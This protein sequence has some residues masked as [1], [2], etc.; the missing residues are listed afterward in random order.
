MAVL[1]AP[2]FGLAALAFLLAYWRTGKAWLE[3]TPFVA[4]LVG[5]M[6]AGGSLL[7]GYP[8]YLAVALLFMYVPLWLFGPRLLTLVSRAHS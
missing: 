6:T 5:A 4:I 7:W 2:I 1:H 3:A 8:Q